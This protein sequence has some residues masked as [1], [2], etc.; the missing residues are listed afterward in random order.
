MLR[1]IQEEFDLVAWVQFEDTWKIPKGFGD[2]DTM[3]WIESAEKQRSEASE[4]RRRLTFGCPIGIVI[5]PTNAYGVMRQL[6][7][8]LDQINTLTIGTIGIC[9]DTLRVARH[10]APITAGT[11]P[12][13]MI[14]LERNASKPKDFR[15]TVPKAII[16]ECQINRHVAKALLDSSS[17]SDFISTTLVDQLK[18]RTEH[19][20]KP[21][22][23]QMAAT[24]SRTMITSLV[25][26]QFT[27]QNIVET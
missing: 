23:C 24:G 6:H 7:Q 25:E 21:I 27:Y 17:L 11:Y 1:F 10:T 26:P 14:G 3:V 12:D 16:I 13:A 9:C 20:T 5:E 15:C 19:L 2:H 18:L 4:Y 22:T 8:R